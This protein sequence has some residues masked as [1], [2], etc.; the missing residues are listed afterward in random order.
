MNIREQ[1]EK[2][3]TDKV[4]TKL[5]SERVKLGLVDDL[6]KLNTEAIET[7]K[8]LSSQSSDLSKLFQEVRNIADEFNGLNDQRNNEIK[9]GKAIFK[10]LN[11][12]LDAIQ[13]QAKDL[14]LAPKDIPNFSKSVTANNS[15]R[16][17]T[18]DIQKYSNIKI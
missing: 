12:K 17:A 7:E 9:K 13:K 4:M 15:L 16:A 8:L 3:I 10:E 1:I 18:N 14:G 6:K 11:S 5:A 2:E